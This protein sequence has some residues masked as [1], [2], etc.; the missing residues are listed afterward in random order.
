MDFK[1]YQEQSRKTAIYPRQ[2]D[3][4]TPGNY[5][6]PLLG[7]GG[8][9]GEI[10]NKVKKIER[11][12]DGVLTEEYKQKIA[13]EI[14]DSIWYIAQLCTELGLSLDEI[15]QQNLDKLF[16]RKAAGTIKGSGDK[17]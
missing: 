16:A 15:A 10:Q 2:G 14:S 6:Y 1:Y 17:R 8:E 4:K 9:V 12:F 11:D 13:D 3:G 5:I 7:L